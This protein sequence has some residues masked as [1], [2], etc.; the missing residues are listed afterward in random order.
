MTSK[1]FLT[2]RRTFG[3]AKGDSSFDK[4]ECD[5][6]SHT[7]SSLYPSPYRPPPYSCVFNRNAVESQDP[8][9]I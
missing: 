7:L 5:L 8:V 9:L 6:T 2:T 3:D 4:G 1:G